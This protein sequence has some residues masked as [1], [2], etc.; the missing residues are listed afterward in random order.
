MKI[1]V[2][3]EVT[4]CDCCETEAYLTACLNCGVEHCYECRAKYGK[5]YE[6]AVHF[7]GSNDGYY[8]KKCDA[9]LIEGPDTR[10]HKAYRK[11]EALRN[12]VKAWSSDFQFR[13]AK[14]EEEVRLAKGCRN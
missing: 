8:C 1:T 4:I 12:E 7:S 9:D 11:I 5:T 14:A 6:H 10:Q 3:K 2:M 13:A